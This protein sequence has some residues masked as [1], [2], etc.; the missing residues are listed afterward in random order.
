MCYNWAEMEKLIAGAKKLGIQL[1]SRQ[2]EQFETY[3]RELVDWNQRMNLTAI[4]EYEDVQIKHFLDSLTLSLVWKPST[5]ASIIDV[6]TG[7]GMPGIPLK[8]LYSNIKLV[9]LDSVA[10]KSAFL[11]HLKH[12]LQL[13]DIEVTVGRA[14][15]EAHRPEYREKFNIVLSRA[16][17]ELPTLVEL[18]LP[19]CAIGGIFIAQKK[20]EITDEVERAYHAIALL[21]GK[22]REVRSIELE[23][24][25]EKRYLVIIDK[26]SH[27]PEQY[28]RRAGV[29]KKRPI[30]DKAEYK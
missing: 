19:F 20:G 30:L 15:E 9:L 3:F 29:P 1:N 13:P 12:K 18:A 2:I 23:E 4:T 5:V 27:T 28:P 6:G 14:E 8:I 26:V 17:A 21:G 24:F 10:K 7:A 22:L 25:S 16:V 11:E